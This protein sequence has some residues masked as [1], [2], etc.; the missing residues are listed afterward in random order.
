M[1]E[2]HDAMRGRG[3]FERAVEGLLALLRNGVPAAVRV[4][5]HRRNVHDLEAI[6]RLLLE[7]IGLSSFGTNSASAMGLCR[8]NAELVPVTTA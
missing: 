3:S 1:P 7:D 6:A 5:I 2:S 8:K 4:T